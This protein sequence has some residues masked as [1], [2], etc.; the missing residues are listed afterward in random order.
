M[1]GST[2][3][4]DSITVFDIVQYHYCPRKVYFLRVL[5]VPVVVR[6]KME[7]GREIHDRERRRMIERKQIYGFERE[8]IEEVLQRLRIEASEI[9]LR[10]QVDVALKLKT[11]EF[12]PV[13]TKYTDEV[14][15]QRQYRRQLHAY[16]LLLDHRFKTNVTRGVIY[17][18]K[19]HRIRVVKITNEDKKSLLRDIDHIK[20][21]I[22]SEVI[23]KRVS[24]EKCGY[25][26]VKK[27]C[28]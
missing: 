10:G 19:Q 13:D 22:S 8:L 20:R 21:M 26:E 2:S 6:K 17:F 28:T 1:K 15:V 25:C 23:P 9:S 3:A 24:Q 18:A 27:Y 14:A 7:Y 12:L 16:A 4:G 11:G 5:G